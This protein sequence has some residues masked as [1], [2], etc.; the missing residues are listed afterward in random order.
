MS[1][2]LGKKILVTRD[3]KQSKS[4]CHEI[5]MSG[6]QPVV[7]P[8]IEI[9]HEV[10]E[11]DKKA[12]QNI[13][14]QIEWVIFTSANGIEHFFMEFPISQFDFGNKKFAV[15]GKSTEKSLH[16]Q[17]F[18]ADF[19][20]TKYTGQCLVEEM[21]KY[22]QKDAH[23]LFVKGK[24]AREVIPT[25]LEKEK[26]L[27]HTFTVYNTLPNQEGIQ[28][29]IQLLENKELDVLTFTSPSTVQSFVQALQ[30][31]SLLEK[32]K[33]W[34]IAVIGPTSKEKA[35]ELGLTVSIMPEIYTLSEM[36]KSIQ[37]YFENH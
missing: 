26:Y 19:I 31:T 24:I 5:L 18:K 6:A 16:K 7:I 23:I 3:F 11:S 9:V 10:V 21:D 33:D 15:V 36:L 20:P 35:E 1:E 14:E 27:Y 29:L 17:G 25:Y 2:W 22:I 37:A 4:F 13:F 32:S 30:K 34:V 12:I 8:M 28:K